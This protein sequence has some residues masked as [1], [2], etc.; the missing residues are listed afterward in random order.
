MAFD[1]AKELDSSIEKF[2]GTFSGV[3]YEIG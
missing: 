2:K 1:K 3:N